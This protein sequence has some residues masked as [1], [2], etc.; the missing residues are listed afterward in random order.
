MLPGIVQLTDWK[1]Q[2]VQNLV[3][4]SVRFGKKEVAWFNECETK[5][6]EELAD[7]G[8]ERFHYLDTLLTPALVNIVPRQLKTPINQKGG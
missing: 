2:L 3:A 5:T 4:S 7:S 1:S 6:F 8:E